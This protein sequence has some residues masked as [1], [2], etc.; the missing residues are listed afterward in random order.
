[1]LYFLGICEPY[2][3]SILNVLISDKVRRFTFTPIKIVYRVM[4]FQQ[5][6]FMW[7]FILD[8]E[9]W[10]PVIGRV[11]RSFS[12]MYKM[13]PWKNGSPPLHPLWKMPCP[14]PP[15]LKN[16]PHS[17]HFEKFLAPPPH[18][19]KNAPPLHPLW[20]MPC[21]SQLSLKNAMP[22]IHFEKFLAPLH[23]AWKM[24]CFHLISDWVKF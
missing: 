15:S 6:P 21:P 24:L 4:R 11:L 23:L 12:R 2:F 19:L 20:K 22:S 17:I 14:P 8:N 7:Q 5:G 3:G 1:M 16:A 9:K 10:I 13:L 18:S